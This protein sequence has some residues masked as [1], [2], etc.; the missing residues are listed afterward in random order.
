MILKFIYIP[1]FT[2][3]LIIVI[4]S[5][6]GIVLLGRLCVGMVYSC[7]SIQ[8]CPLTVKDRYEQKRQRACW[9]PT[10]SF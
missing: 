2:V 8:F 1:V 10:V 7:Y 4:S 3:F 9:I 5:I 6:S